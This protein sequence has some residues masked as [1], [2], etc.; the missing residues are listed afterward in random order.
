MKSDNNE[1]VANN[2]ND[3]SDSLLQAPGAEVLSPL[4]ASLLK[5]LSVTDRQRVMKW[6]KIKAELEK[7]RQEKQKELESAKSASPQRNELS[8]PQSGGKIVFTT[9]RDSMP[10]Y[11]LSVR[12]ELLLM[13]Q[14]DSASR[15]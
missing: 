12:E 5:E 14:E 13:S 1:T 9:A 3:Q 4:S 7:E 10:S 11:R 2:D 15:K 6:M 8:D